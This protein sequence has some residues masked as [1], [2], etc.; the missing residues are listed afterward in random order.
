MLATDAN[1]TST[2]PEKAKTEKPRPVA[3]LIQL[4]WTHI[5]LG[6]LS[7]V[8]SMWNAGNATDVSMIL[9]AVIISMPIAA[10]L[11]MLISRGHGWARHLWTALY[12]FHLLFIKATVEQLLTSGWVSRA[13]GIAAEIAI[14]VALTLSYL[15]AARGWFHGMRSAR[16]SRL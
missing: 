14:A 11:T 7:A 13:L 8:W 16:R 1:P 2:L 4:L 12:I 9:F 15:P 5:A 10:V 3:L 6:A